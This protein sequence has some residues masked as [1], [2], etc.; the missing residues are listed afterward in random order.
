MKEM[1]RVDILGATYTIY[2]CENY[3]DNDTLPKYRAGECRAIS[4]EIYLA[5]L[6]DKQRFG[7][8]RLNE[9]DGLEREVLRHE[10]FHAFLNQSG[11]RWNTE[12][13]VNGWATNEEM[14]D[15]LA[16]QSPKIFKVFKELKIEK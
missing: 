11:L 13:S 4:N 10:I 7:D 3:Q 2:K 12:N 16:I 8:L 15:W 5:D 6:T 9:I 1:T 14:V